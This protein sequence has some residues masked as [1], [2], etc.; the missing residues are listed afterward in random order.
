MQKPV[1]T[2]TSI[3]YIASGDAYRED[4]IEQKGNKKRVIK[5]RVVDRKYVK[6][7]NRR[8]PYEFY[9][10][11]LARQEYLTSKYA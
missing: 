7:G 5:S 2:Y 9:L 8:T 10:D 4:L 1:Y 11:D 3:R 6:S